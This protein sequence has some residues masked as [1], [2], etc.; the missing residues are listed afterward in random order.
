[1]TMPANESASYLRL[2]AAA[3]PGSATSGSAAPGVQEQTPDEAVTVMYQAYYA[4]LV[5]LAA[6]LVGDVATAETAHPLGDPRRHPR[7]LP[8]PRLHPHLLAPTAQPLTLS[9]ALRSGS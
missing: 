1:M 4:G 6:V 8:Q 7:S 2:R 5:R 3:P 9:K